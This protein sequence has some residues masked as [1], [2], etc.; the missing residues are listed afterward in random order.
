MIYYR[1]VYHAD[2]LLM[3]KLFKKK[4]N[5][6]QIK[7]DLL[8]LLVLRCT[9]ENPDRLSWTHI[10]YVIELFVTD[11]ELPQIFPTGRLNNWIV[12]IMIIIFFSNINVI[13]HTNIIK[14]F[15]NVTGM[16]RRV[17]GIWRNWNPRPISVRSWGGDTCTAVCLA[18]PVY[19]RNKRF[20]RPLVS[21]DDRRR[22]LRIW[23]T[24]ISFGN[25][26]PRMDG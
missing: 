22:P 16:R 25:Y 11:P 17:F 15:F 9:V 23:R 10:R 13:V 4:K 19:L 24:R 18:E 7:I 14:F 1:I 6:F 8:T 5:Q 21:D 20:A 12:S 2:I 3:K 26:F